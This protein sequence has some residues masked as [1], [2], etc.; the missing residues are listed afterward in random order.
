M[1]EKENSH[2]LS[3][4][5]NL[6][7]QNPFYSGDAN[8]AKGETYEIDGFDDLYHVAENELLDVERKGKVHAKHPDKDE[9]DSV[10][11][12]DSLYTIEDDP[13]LVGEVSGRK[14][15]YTPHQYGKILQNLGRAMEQH[16]GI[17]P[18]GKASVS[19]TYHRFTGRLGL[20][21]EFEPLDGDTYELEIRFDS[22]N[23][24]QKSTSYEVGATR[25]ICTNGQRAWDSEFTFSQTHQEPLNP[26]MAFHAVDSI[27][28]GVDSYSKRIA[29]AEEEKMKSLDD[30][31]LTILDTGIGQYFDDPVPKLRRALAE[32]VDDPEQPTLKET[33][34][35][36]T[37]AVT[38]YTD[39]LPEYVLS[40][41]LGITSNLLDQ[42]GQLPEAEQ[43]GRR[44]VEKRA[45]QYIED[46]DNVEPNWEDEE[47]DVRQLME[48]HGITS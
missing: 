5:K 32:E 19:K 43:L 40:D 23:T 12:R 27:L 7:S 14:E 38:H 16:D 41:A 39:N 44:A 37:R 2:A 20:G 4:F 47:E 9:Q 15:H 36:A 28:E 18:Q 29:L 3:I 26:N 24:G 48:T 46:R 34:D 1:S 8:I 17:Y 11:W 33:Y 35:A 45:N 10:F 25:L 22:G 13:R 31:I 21:K 42:H 6:I 30:S